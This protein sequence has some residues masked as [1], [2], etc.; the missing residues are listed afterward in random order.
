[1]DVGWRTR[2]GKD[3]DGAT[4]TVTG[5][6]AEPNTVGTSLRELLRGMRDT[7]SDSVE[8]LTSDH[9]R[10]VTVY[11]DQGALEQL[12]RRG[13]KHREPL[14][15]Q[16]RQGRPRTYDWDEFHREVIRIANSPD[17]LPDRPAD[18]ERMMATWC[19]SCWGKE[20][21]SSMIRKKISEIYQHVKKAEK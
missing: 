13:D 16:K 12:L 2:L 15:V 1:M 4:S 14:E 9:R 18:L 17:G 6:L 10:G 8:T 3:I 7:A 19:L 20:P 11:V 21:V 5:L